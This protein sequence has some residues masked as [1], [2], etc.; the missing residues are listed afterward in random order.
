MARLF[1]V[2]LAVLLLVAVFGQA[3]PSAKNLEG[4]LNAP[5]SVSGSR[6][7]HLQNEHT[8]NEHTGNEHTGDEDELDEDDN[9]PE[10]INAHLTHFWS[11]AFLTLMAKEPE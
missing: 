6:T 7:A 4:S 1:L 10:L 2:S 11:S 8:G 9:G 5:A 3:A